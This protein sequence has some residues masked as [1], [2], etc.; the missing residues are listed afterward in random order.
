MGSLTLLEQ[1]R[2]DTAREV[3]RRLEVARTESARLVADAE[4]RSAQA[5]EGALAQ[6]TRDAESDRASALARAQQEHAG[7]VLAARAAAIDR[8][9]VTAAAR[10]ESLHDD[11]RLPALLA[12]LLQQTLPFL[13]DGPATV[14]YSPSIASLVQSAVAAA[15]RPE[16]SV[17]PA[18]GMS[19]G[20]IVTSG[21]GGL[22]VDATL[23]RRLAR[24][25]GELA[26]E[27]ASRLQEAAP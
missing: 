18:E 4:A 12:R 1:L 8:I 23:A 25:R 27:L 15:G 7:V 21:D 2:A 19:L 16:L 11:P 6:H 17:Q 14:R 9:F 3:A 26:I 13:P 22:S 20:V 24:S 10:L 5:H